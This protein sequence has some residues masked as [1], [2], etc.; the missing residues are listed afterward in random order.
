MKIYV[1]DVC[2]Q[3][4]GKFGQIY[5]RILVTFTGDKGFFEE[6]KDI[7]RSCFEDML[8]YMRHNKPKP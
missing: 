6:R 1:C 5:E 3:S 4:I 2:S 8:A 7:C